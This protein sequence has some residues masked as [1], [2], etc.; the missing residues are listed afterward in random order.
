MTGLW[1]NVVDNRPTAGASGGLGLQIQILSGRSDAEMKML[2]G[3]CGKKR[4]G[5]GED[6][7]VRNSPQEQ[8][9][10]IESGDSLANTIR[11]SKRFC[12]NQQL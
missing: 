12:L 2:E 9:S 3:V 1:T 7:F 11:G 4:C 5:F 6:D 8:L 10:V